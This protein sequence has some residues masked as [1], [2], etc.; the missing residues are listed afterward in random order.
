[1]DER[2]DIAATVAALAVHVDAQRWDD[3]LSLFAPEVEVDYTSLFGGDA[4]VLPRER[5][6]ERWRNFL[7]G[8][9]QTCHLIGAPFIQMSGETAKVSASVSAWHFLKGHQLQGK[10][11]WL[12][13]GCYEIECR[14]MDAKWRISE[15][16]LARAWVKGNSDL[17]K[18][19]QERAAAQSA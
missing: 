10:D 13:G 14:K 3:L 12:V 18:L 2:N 15:L 4:E 1:M 5:L 16:K 11:Y 19:A 7:P 6:I 17:P 8:F 9:T